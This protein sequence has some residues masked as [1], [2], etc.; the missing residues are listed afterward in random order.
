MAGHRRDAYRRC[1]PFNGFGALFVTVSSV[2][3]SPP[4]RIVSIGRSL[5]RAK[6]RDAA[7]QSALGFA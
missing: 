5:T 7:L 4:T 2:M 6:M 3:R 1:D